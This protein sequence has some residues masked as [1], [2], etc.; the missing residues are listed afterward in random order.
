MRG[1]VVAAEQAAIQLAPASARRRA[2]VV[3]EANSG[4]R[5]AGRMATSYTRIACLRR[6]AE[7]NGPDSRP[8]SAISTAARPVRAFGVATRNR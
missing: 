8:D 5:M 4:L 3:S 1:A 6:A 2:G 7:R